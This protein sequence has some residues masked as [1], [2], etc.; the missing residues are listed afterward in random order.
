MGQSYDAICQDC[1]H[2]CKVHD[3]PAMLALLFHCDRC[4]A[5][6]F[7]DLLQAEQ[8]RSECPDWSQDQPYGPAKAKQ[9]CPACGGTFDTEAPPRCPKC[10]SSK[11]VRDPNSEN[12]C[13]D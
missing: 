7:M 2:R 6:L 9:R 12:I 8:L 5:E 3:G 13:F 1:G 11:L 4:G 10:R